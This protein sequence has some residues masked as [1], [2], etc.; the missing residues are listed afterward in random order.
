MV[1]PELSLKDRK[2]HTPSLEKEGTISW[3]QEIVKDG[4]SFVLSNKDIVLLANRAKKLLESFR[5]NKLG[6]SDDEKKWV[7][8][9]GVPENMEIIF[10]N[11]E[12]ILNQEEIEQF[13]ILAVSEK[14]YWNERK[15]LTWN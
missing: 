7:D 3:S 5:N 11:Q 9:S 6:F 15:A 4:I 8:L 1:N 12:A 14:D 13:K 2:E 10:W